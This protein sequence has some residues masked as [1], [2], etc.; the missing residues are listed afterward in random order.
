MSIIS[1]LLQLTEYPG[2]STDF[3]RKRLHL[4][5]SLY[6]KTLEA[7][8]EGE[9]QRLSSADNKDW[10]THLQVKRTYMLSVLY[11]ISYGYQVDP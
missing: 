4:G 7:I 2:A 9:K 11:D 6:F 3:A 10:K 1:E 5:E 8:V